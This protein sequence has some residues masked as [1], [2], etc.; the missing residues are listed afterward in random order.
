MGTKKKGLVGARRDA[1]LIF[2]ISYLVSEKRKR[3]DP[4][5]LVLQKC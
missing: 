3:R 1:K 5:S 4:I 2:K